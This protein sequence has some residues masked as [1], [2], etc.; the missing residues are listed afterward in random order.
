M[1][2]LKVFFKEFF[3]KRSIFFSLIFDSFLL[4]FR[5]LW[6]KIVVY[7]FIFNYSFMEGLILKKKKISKIILEEKK[8][9]NNLFMMLLR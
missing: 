3:S 4:I 1:V 7:F 6:L 9:F 2:F 8:V 5:G